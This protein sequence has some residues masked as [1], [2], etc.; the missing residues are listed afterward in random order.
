VNAE[1]GPPHEAGVE[2]GTTFGEGEKMN[3]QTR[4][5]LAEVLEAGDRR[6]REEVI[7]QQARVEAEACRGRVGGLLQEVVRPELEEFADQ[8]TAGG[9]RCQVTFQD[10]GHPRPS[11]SLYLAQERMPLDL[12]VANSITFRP[13]LGRE[14]VFMHQRIRGLRG[15]RN[16]SRGVDLSL[17]ELTAEKVDQLVLTF[18]ERL[19]GT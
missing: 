12:G 19:I 5:R 16:L 7:R 15:R 4:K 11:V 8:L 13:G 17:A 18:V 14:T 10:E 1:A 6:R 2:R 9:R 3:E